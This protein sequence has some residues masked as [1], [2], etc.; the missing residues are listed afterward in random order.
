MKKI[1]IISDIHANL[2]ALQTIR[3]YMDN[4]D[5][6]CALNLGDFISNGPNPCEVFDCIMADQRFIN[7]RGY[8]EE[9]L[10]DKNKRN[11]GIGQG[12]WLVNQLGKER[13]D[14]LSKM[15]TTKSIQ[16]NNK[17]FLMSH[18]NG[19]S[20]MLQEEAHRGKSSQEHYDYITYGGSHLQELCHTKDIFFNTNILD[21][22]TL[23]PNKDNKGNFVLMQFSD[24][25]PTIQFCNILISKQDIVESPQKAIIEKEKLMKDA[26]LYI[27]GKTKSN[28]GAMYIN[29]EVVEEVIKVGIRQCKYVCIGCWKHE[30]Q[31]IREI[32]YYLKCRGIRS[33]DKDNQEWYIGEITKDVEEL[34]LK[35]RYSSDGKLKWFEISF[36]DDIS[37]NLM[38][39]SIYQYGQQCFLRELSL[40]DLYKMQ[41]LLKKYDIAYK[42]PEQL[43]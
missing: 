25:E 7:I 26:F 11:E 14:I 40:H 24:T 38:M 32:L 13:I 4:E 28:D 37:S 18:H 42:I 27:K 34:L 20:K 41:V 9:S 43:E 16:I 5:I 1:V 21:P 6:D 19:W 17:K 29:D 22:G 2:D 33:S 8:D 39:Y 31:L 12:E 23:A 3:H 36:L 10:F 35:K 30:K 15:P